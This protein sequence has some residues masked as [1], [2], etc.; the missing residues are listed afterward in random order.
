MPPLQQSTTTSQMPAHVMVQPS[1]AVVAD[2]TTGGKP[3]PDAKA[4][5]TTE[6]NLLQHLGWGLGR[7]SL[8]ITD[9]QQVTSLPPSPSHEALKHFWQHFFSMSWL[10]GHQNQALHAQHGTAQQ[11]RHS[12][13]QQA[14]HEAAAAAQLPY[15]DIISSSPMPLARQEEVVAA[16]LIVKAAGSTDTVHY[17][18][19]KQTGQSGLTDAP[20]ITHGAHKQTEGDT[21][22]CLCPTQQGYMATQPCL[23]AWPSQ[24]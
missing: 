14:E 16:H 8:D 7:R 10:P 4:M 15:D 9:Q 5:S 2:A 17:D 23:A 6:A 18:L 20:I 22:A 21:S 1:S 19:V 12:T 24:V 11:A 13:A 3:A